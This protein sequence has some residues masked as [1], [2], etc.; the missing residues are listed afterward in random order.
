MI[1]ER[2][3]VV[4]NVMLSLISVLSPP[5]DLCNISVCTDV[6]L[7]ILGVLALGASLVP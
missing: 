7:C 5:P 4:V 3:S 6:K 2:M 1:V